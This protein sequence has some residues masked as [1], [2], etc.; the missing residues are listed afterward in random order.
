[1]DLSAFNGRKRAEEGVFVPLCHPYTGEPIG[2]GEDAPGFLVRGSASRS[3]QSKLAELQKEAEKASGGDDEEAVME[4]LHKTMIDSAMK[5]II[6]PR[7]IEN[8]GKAVE[9]EAE[10]RAVLDMTFPEM[11]V[12]T[13]DNGAPVM[14][15]GK[16]EDGN[17]VDIPKFEMANQT[18]ARQVITAAEDGARFLEGLPKG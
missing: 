8:E 10:I 12:V 18:F 7:N 4:S 1:M 5:Y 6:A 17:T 11:K 15:Q 9:T 3:V 2:N 14:T 16:D 13:D